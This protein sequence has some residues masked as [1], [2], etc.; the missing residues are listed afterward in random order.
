MLVLLASRVSSLQ[1]RLWPDAQ[2]LVERLGRDFFRQ[3]PE[4]PGVYLMQGAA[5]LVLYVGKAKNLRHRLGSYRVANPERMARRTLRLLNLVE[6]IGWE[7]CDSESTALRR[8]SELLLTLKPRFNRAG[9]WPAPKRFLV[10]RMAEV[11]LELSVAP[12]FEPGWQRFGPMGRGAVHLQGAL[13]RLLWLALNPTRAAS[14]LPV[15]WA[16]GRFMDTTTLDCDAAAGEVRRALETFFGGEPDAFR[17]WLGAKLAARAAPFER[18]LIQSD[19]ETLDE[20]QRKQ[21]SPEQDGHPL[22]LR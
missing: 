16:Q 17:S 21:R 5:G 19:W 1:Q 8:E 14:D 9:V 10:W 20:F 18:R 7:E 13:A 12:A 4:R 6:R 22:A 15:G 2:P 11:R 3:V